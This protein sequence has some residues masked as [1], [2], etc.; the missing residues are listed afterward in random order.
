[1]M[2][3]E[4]RGRPAIEQRDSSRLRGPLGDAKS[5]VHSL[6]NRVAALE[7]GWRITGID[8]LEVRH[9]VLLSRRLPSAA[10]GLRIL[11][12]SDL[13][14]ESLPSPNNLE[15]RIKSLQFDVSVITG[16][17]ASGPTSETLAHDLCQGL[18]ARSPVYA[19]L[20]NHDLG[21]LASTLTRAGVKVLMNDAEPFVGAAESVWVVGVDDPFYYRTADLDLAASRVPLGAITLLLA[22]S[23]DASERAAAA[24]MDWYLCGHTHGGHI[25][26]AHRLLSR[27]FGSANRVDG[28]WCA[29]Q[30]LGY[31][32]RG[33]GGFGGL[34]R[35]NC[36]PEITIHTLARPRGRCEGHEHEDPNEVR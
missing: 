27:A 29:G 11:H 9:N 20:G 32:S 34:H 26:P 10:V 35:V 24:G 21:S 28:P 36:P 15:D 30:M 8:H 31:T 33:V 17:I 14:L 23:P 1:M 2:A 4:L 22:H 13:H 7:I 18:A 5:V 3:I 19:V 12:L 6:V 16:D 25:Q